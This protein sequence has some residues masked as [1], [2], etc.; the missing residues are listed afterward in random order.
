MHR[1]LLVQSLQ[2]YR[3]HSHQYS[4]KMLAAFCSQPLYEKMQPG[5]WG[6]EPC[7]CLH[8]GAAFLLPVRLPSAC[9]LAMSFVL[10]PCSLP[11]LSSGSA[12]SNAKLIWL[13][14]CEIAAR[15]GDASQFDFCCWADRDT[16]WRG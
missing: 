4:L 8:V 14:S 10:P 16:K 7:I 15:D 11:F 2:A 12:S 5:D 13:R 9:L 1:D 6:M 3:H